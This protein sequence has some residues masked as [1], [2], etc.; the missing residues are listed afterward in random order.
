[1]FPSTVS[2][3]AR[4]IQLALAPAFL[5]GGV[6]SFLSVLTNRLGRI[7][8][9]ARRI[10]ERLQAATPAE[11][12][13]LHQALATLSKRA[14]LM[15]AAITLCTLSV[16]LIACVIVALFLSALVHPTLDR[17]SSFLFIGAMMAL[18]AGMGFFL[19]EIFVATSALRIGPH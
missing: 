19:R 6:A 14:K 18:V 8:D 16:L 11:S 12:A 7:I 9:R 13:A 5:V 15:S 4:V 3:T 2:E 17:V 1:M 10:E